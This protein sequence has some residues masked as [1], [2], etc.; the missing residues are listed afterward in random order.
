VTQP[1][2]PVIASAHGAWLRDVAGRE[3]LDLNAGY[4]S[5]WLGHGN[6]AVTRALENQLRTYAAPGFLDN[7]TREAAEAALARMIPA[8]QRIGGIYSTGMEAMET[9]IRAAQAH[10]GRTAVAGFAGST[11]GRSFLTSAIGS[12]DGAEIPGYVYR[13]PAFAEGDDSVVRAMER[14]ARQVELAAIVVEPIQMTGGGFELSPRAACALFEIAAAHG[15]A[16]IFD[17]TLTGLYRCG[18]SSYSAMLDVT[19][20]I[21]VLGKGLANGFPAAAV[22]LRHDFTWDRSH[23]RPGSTFWNHPLTCAAISAAAQALEALEPARRVAAIEAAVLH[24][25][26]G[27]RLRGRG[28]LWCVELPNAQS[29]PEFVAR[30]L[31]AGVVASYFPR[32][33]RLLPPVTID[34][35]ELAQGCARIR[36]AHAAT[37]W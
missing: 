13:L 11:H 23:V 37:R 26:E 20:D 21:T 5:V 32:H 27:L 9:S 10:T 35:A 18:A 1:E 34:V 12:K 33:I 31:D 28:A 15:I 30:L 16:V 36:E 2:L 25:L 24:E 22:A 8:A 3:Y 19:P 7:G 4:G 29:Q 14:L 6:E 17:E